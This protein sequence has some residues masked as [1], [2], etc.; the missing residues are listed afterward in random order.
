MST[1]ESKALAQDY[2]EKLINAHNLAA[3]DELFDPNIAFHDSGV[4]GGIAQGLK[5]VSLFFATFFAA[6]P[7]VHFTIEDLLA[8][9]DKVAARFTWHGTHRDKF[10]GIVPTHKPVTI[11]G[12][13]IFHIAN[14]KIVEVRVSGDT[15]LFVKQV[16]E[17]P[18]LG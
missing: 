13:D 2:F 16:I 14:G 3:V 15:L 5:A 8:E 6:F 1:E 18:E 11:P 9:G 4:P 7:D 12:I 17:L 10:L